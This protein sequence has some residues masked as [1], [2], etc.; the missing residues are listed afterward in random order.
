MAVG[1]APG[2]EAELGPP[3]REG[4]HCPA[5]KIQGQPKPRKRLERKREGR[6]RLQEEHGGR[7]RCCTQNP[8]RA[9]RLAIKNS[10]ILDRNS[11]ILRELGQNPPPINISN[12]KP[13]V[14]TDPNY[15]PFCK[16]D[17]NCI[18]RSP[19]FFIENNH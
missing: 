15:H 6:Q 14:K 4:L 16:K 8:P 11:H 7:N 5:R 1:P 19:K 10:H 9:A 13:A 3:P 2:P 18:A 17:E 12:A